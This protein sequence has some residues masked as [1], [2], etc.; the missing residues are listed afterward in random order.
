[1]K[2]ESMRVV[3]GS[4]LLSIMLVA[5]SGT[6]ASNASSG[7]TVSGMH[8]S[9]N[10]TASINAYNDPMTKSLQGLRG[11]DFEITFLQEMIVHHQ[12]AIVMAQL[13]PT[14]TKRPELNTLAKS[15][16]TEQS[17]EIAKMITWLK[18]WYHEKPPADAM[19]VPGMMEMMGAM[20]ALSSAQGASFDK[21]F[22]TMM[23]QH[24]DQG[25]SMAQ[26]IPQRT[27]Q[28]TLIQLGQTMMKTQSAEIL[29]MKSW[30]QQ[31][32]KS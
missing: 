27:T 30:Q 25:V 13:V 31:W 23:I 11:K 2:N 16:I 3:L 12:S 7:S 4:L 21:Q 24:H 10:P 26:L 9:G 20:D 18:Q 6:A 28:P 5:C 14:H 17:G 32:F 8:P 22:T 1:M 29:Q 15:I 19:S